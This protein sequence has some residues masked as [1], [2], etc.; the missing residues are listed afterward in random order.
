MKRISSFLA[1]LALVT[2]LAPGCAD[3]RGAA[4]G[5]DLTVEEPTGVASPRFV[6]PVGCVDAD[7]DGSRDAP[8]RGL[9]AARGLTAGET[10]VLLPGTYEGALQLPGGV[11]AVVALPERTELTRGVTVEGAGSS[12]LSGMRIESP[13]EFGLRVVGATVTLESSRIRGSTG[14][15]I[16]VREA[17]SLALRA[18]AV[19]Q[20][21]GVGVL[22]KGAGAISIVEPIFDVGPRG[23][24]DDKIGI[25]EPIFLPSTRI[26]GNVGGG[27]AIVE[28]IFLP[29][30]DAGHSLLLEGAMVQGNV[31]FGVALYGA[32]ARIKASA[33]VSTAIG[34]GGPWADGVLLAAAADGKTPA[35]SVEAD[36]VIAG[37][38]RGGV[39]ALAKSAVSVEADVSNNG[40]AGVWVAA[41]GATLSI[42]SAARLYR[43]HLV[44]AGVSAGARLTVDGATF[45]ET[46]ALQ[47]EGSSAVA[48]G[49][50]I[51]DGARA[52]ITGA[53]M[54]DN[55]RAAVLVHD[56]G[57]R[58]DGSIDVTIDG[59]T[60]VGG[61]FAVVV[62]GAQAPD[63]AAQNAYEAT[64][65][66]NGAGSG[67]GEPAL[68]PSDRDDADLAAQ[69][70][71]CTGGGNCLPGV[72]D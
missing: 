3:M 17:G 1:G 18:S 28:P 7:G 62:N 21:A 9:E 67:G 72:P 26:E 66:E 23:E 52:T 22:A 49:I 35:L 19:L 47:G 57:T 44:A 68:A 63:F 37:N 34:S 5:C 4:A 24:G 11:D 14:H 51:F 50:G 61:Q 55:V 56:A 36:S 29:A 64:D 8:F 46:R 33:I 71:Y 16:E 10:L 38:A 15:G 39:V 48:D 20:S 32:S 69:T 6:A 42:G 2:G 40:Y 27:I 58:R 45:A 13:E 30:P 25:V 41:E 12:R 70:D 31:G 60:F 54:V 59:S 43:N 65:S 53:R